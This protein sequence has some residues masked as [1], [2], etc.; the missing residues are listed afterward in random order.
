MADDK[1][2]VSSGSRPR[3]RSL[4]GRAR[5]SVDGADLAPAVESTSHPDPDAAADHRSILPPN[6]WQSARLPGFGEP[7]D[8]CGEVIPESI[9]FCSECGDPKRWSRNCMRYDCPEHAAAAIRRRAA[10]SADGAGVVP[11]L[12]AIRRVLNSRR[13]E[14]QRYHHLVVDLPRRWYF[15]SNEPMKRAVE[16]VRE[17]MDQLGIQGLVAF[18]PWRGADE[19]PDT[20]D[21]GEWR[22][23]LFG[24]REW[25]NDVRGEL[26]P[27]PHFHIVGVA[28]FID[29]SDVG[30][31]YD[32]TGW[33]IHRITQEGS[34]VSIGNDDQMAA[35][36]TYCLSHSMVYDTG[37]TRRLAAWIKGPDT[38]WITPTERNAQRAKAIVNSVA[39]D[40]LGTPAP[41]FEC[42]VTGVDVADSLADRLG[43]GEHT[44][45]WSAGRIGTP[46][47]IRPA[48]PRGPGDAPTAPH[49]SS[50]ATVSGGGG[51]GGGGGGSSSPT[52]SADPLDADAYRD[53]DADECGGHIRHISAAG[54]FLLDGEWRRA[55]PFADRLDD[56]YH[57]FVESVT[58][59]DVDARDA[60]AEIPEFDDR[61]PPD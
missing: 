37:S 49:S 27:D 20:N 2:A 60:R 19:D 1:A 59:R 30:E 17:L 3:G 11:K 6:A 38:H 7:L 40:T 5:F 26:E 44:D 35:A 25:R 8:D 56:L 43:Y 36:A 23:R 55:A 9:H 14:N 32:R 28:P 39:E 41:S 53:D 54:D 31:F 45:E 18:H 29:L 33:I 47:T 13:D 46:T 22:D 48:E 21:M 50:G 24:D 42:D 57:E 10:G 16:C 61:P 34:N 4:E 51:G 58:D 52:R 12:D 15:E